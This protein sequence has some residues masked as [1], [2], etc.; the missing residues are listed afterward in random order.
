MNEVKKKVQGT[1]NRL[2]ELKAEIKMM[3][4]EKEKA[5]IKYEI[6]AKDLQLR[7]RVLE[8]QKEENIRG[9][10]LDIFSELI[11]RPAEEINRELDQVYRLRYR[12]TEQRNYTSDIIVNLLT[13]RLKDEI[14]LKSMMNP[15]ECDGK[16]IRI[17]KDRKIFRKLTEKLYKENVRFKWELPHGLSFMYKEERRM[18]ESEAQMNGFFKTNDR[19]M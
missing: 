15:I 8:E 13:R 19:R 10:I 6:R 11:E 2:K 4:A 5:E 7:I 9:N 3:K 17:L 18:I 14:F 12:L 16:K 1:D